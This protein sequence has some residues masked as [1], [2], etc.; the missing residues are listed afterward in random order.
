MHYFLRKT[1]LY[2]FTTRKIIRDESLFIYVKV[3]CG[4]YGM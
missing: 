4:K 2:A 1:K 3:T